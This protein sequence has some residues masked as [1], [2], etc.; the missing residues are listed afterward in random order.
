MP[1]GAGQWS[2][3]SV[4]SEVLAVTHPRRC[5]P[6]RASVGIHWGPGVLPTGSKVLQ[7][8][9]RQ[10][11]GEAAFKVQPGVLSHR[12]VL[13]FR[14]SCAS[15]PSR[16]PADKVLP[17]LIEP[18]ELRAAKLREFLEDVKPS[19]CYDIVP[20]ADPFGPSV[21][22][23]NLQCLVV[24][25]ETRRGGEAVNRKRLENVIPMLEPGGLP[26]PALSP[27]LMQSGG[28][29]GL[30][31]PLPSAAFSW[32]MA[33]RA[34]FS[35][36]GLPELALH[37]IQLMKDPDHRQNEEEKI[38][39]SSLRQRLLGTLLQPPRVR[40]PCRATA[41]MTVP[42]RRGESLRSQRVWK[43]H[44][45]LCRP[46][47]FMAWG[48]RILLQPSPVCCHGFPLSLSKTQPCHCA[49]T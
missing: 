3:G 26:L 39:S 24:S 31:S 47:P 44:L 36:Q 1:P 21:T 35:H 8:Q 15:P 46:G 41:A 28:K 42:G 34:P 6:G 12:V 13:L 4:T 14:H 16:H 23:P 17:E 49:R 30:D 32:L 25:E 5:R 45:L 37:E 27:S 40:G 9:R 7:V 18:Y 33:L 19:L 11:E 10:G 20:L 38:S 48:V 29:F 2:G 22:D 43:D